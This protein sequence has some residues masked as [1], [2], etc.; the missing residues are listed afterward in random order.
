MF[1]A[2]PALVVR[3]IGE[4]WHTV[5]HSSQRILASSSGDGTNI[6]PGLSCEG[7]VSIPAGKGIRPFFIIHNGP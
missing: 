1:I 3:Y 5:A 4:N 7:N 6:K 2:Y